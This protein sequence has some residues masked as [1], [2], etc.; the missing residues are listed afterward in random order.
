MRSPKRK[1]HARRGRVG[2][3]VRIGIGLALLALLGC[4]SG[5]EGVKAGEPSPLEPSPAPLIPAS[6][7]LPGDFSPPKDPPVAPP[8]VA[9]AAPPWFGFETFPGAEPLCDE[10][11]AVAPGGK[12][13]EIHWASYATASPH[14]E[15]SSFY[16]R[17]DAGAP[18]QDRDE[19]TFANGKALRLSVIRLPTSQPY[20]RCERGP[21]PTHRTVLVVSRAEAR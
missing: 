20:P 18:E 6:A 4:K 5:A 17:H 8:P 7:T 13:R 11:V 16:K 15:V 9:S 14:Y 12:L 19:T 10:H 1:A 3:G 2:I 21:K